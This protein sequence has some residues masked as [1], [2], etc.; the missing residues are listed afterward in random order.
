M[1]LNRIRMVSVSSRIENYLRSTTMVSYFKNSFTF[2]N[3]DDVGTANQLLPRFVTEK[4]DFTD[5]NPL[6]G[7]QCD[8]KSKR[9]VC[10]QGATSCHLFFFQHRI[11]F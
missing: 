11:L 5:G 4:A 2:T 1:Y 6:R 8:I 7:F 10:W 9:E 3:D